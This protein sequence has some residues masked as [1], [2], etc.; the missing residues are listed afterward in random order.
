[1]W[2]VG[3]MGYC[4]GSG[5]HGNRCLFSFRFGVVVFL[6]ALS[7]ELDNP[8]SLVLHPPVS[9]TLWLSADVQVCQPAIAQEVRMVV[10]IS[11]VEPG[12]VCM[13]ESRIYPWLY[14]SLH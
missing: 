5:L 3:Q 9:P 1:M 13:S 12:F 14:S 8:G 2:C 7:R 6:F 10:V 4:S 11:V